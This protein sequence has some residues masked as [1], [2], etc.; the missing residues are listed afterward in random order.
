MKVLK[1]LFVQLFTGANI[2]TILLLWACCLVTYI[3][4]AAHPR[5]ALLTLT[6]PAFLLV[7]LLF[8]LFWLVFK[9]KRVWIPIVGLL[10]CISFVRD[11]LPLNVTMTGKAPEDSTLSILT[12][13]THNFGGAE[14][15]QEDGTNKVCY[16]LANSNADIICLQE[17]SNKQDFTDEM[18]GKGY[19][20]AYRKEYLLYSR[21]HIIEVD[22]LALEGKPCH[23]LRALLQDG[24][25]TLML[26]SVHLQSNMLSPEMKDAYREALRK[27]ESDSLSKELSPIFRLLSEAMPLRMAQTDSLANLV[28][29]WLPRPVILC[30]DF[31]DTPISYTHRV[32]TTQLTSAYRQSGNG[33]GFTF[34][35]KGFPVRID[36]ILF[37]GHTWESTSTQVVKHITC[38]D[39]FPIY[40]KLRRKKP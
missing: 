2:V 16:Y 17:S 14:A 13:N 27:H 3:S 33:L 4:P 28:A 40:T 26:V 36:H 39:H 11:Y 31:N 29:S 6:F 10:A 34:H 5:L 19:E 25:D 18:E 1:S 23:A 20:F 8:I 7:N 32:L 35:E 15:V 22:T 9:V 21:L 38:S 37:D 24:R 30:G 12:Y